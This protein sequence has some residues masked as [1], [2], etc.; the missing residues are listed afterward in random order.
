M[1]KQE[2]IEKYGEE[3]WKAHLEYNKQYKQQHKDFNSHM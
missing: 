3:A 2:C 1:K